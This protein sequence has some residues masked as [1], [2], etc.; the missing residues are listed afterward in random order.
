MDQDALVE[1]LE[2][3]REQG[4][5]LLGS[6]LLDDRLVQLAP[7]R[8]QGDHAMVGHAAV[9]GVK[10]RRDHVDA[11]HHSGAAAVGL[12]VDLARPERRVVAV[13]EQAQVELV[14]EHGSDRTLLSEPGERMWDESED[15]ELQ[16][17]GRESG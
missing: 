3:G 4:Q 15:V 2:A 16:E 17:N 9:D 11:Q 6:K 1:A 8:R 5:A 13:A 14:A 7:L 12:V 10:S